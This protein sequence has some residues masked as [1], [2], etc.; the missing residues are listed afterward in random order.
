[1]ADYKFYGNY[2]AN[3]IGRTITFGSK[4]GNYFKEKRI[5]RMFFVKGK[6]KGRNI[7]KVYPRLPL[8]E[9]GIPVRVEEGK[10]RIPEKAKKEFIEY[11][12]LKPGEV[13]IIGMEATPSYLE[14][15]DENKIDR[16]ADPPLSDKNMEQ[17]ADL[18]MKEEM[19]KLRVH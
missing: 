19:K 14:I 4:L 13:A 5:S 12:G 6:E 3:L 15:W 16:I 18:L 17:V 11:A 2:K 9:D 10:F 1:M 7:I 8:G